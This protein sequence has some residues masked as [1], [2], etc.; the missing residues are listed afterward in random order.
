[1]LGILQL[2][3]FTRATD[4]S[5]SES[6]S[7][8]QKGAYHADVTN[9]CNVLVLRLH[10]TKLV[11]R[12]KIVKGEICFWHFLVSCFNS[13]LGFSSSAPCFAN[14]PFLTSRH[15]QN[16]P[17]SFVSWKVRELVIPAVP[18]VPRT[19]HYGCAII[20]FPV[21]YSLSQCAANNQH[22]SVC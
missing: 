22:C 1:M 17:V 15:W 9:H 7:G 21:K 4:S 18:S 5:Y 3:I 13:L 10:D 14:I 2:K 16:L 8:L 19:V 20:N 6:L 12:H 11:T